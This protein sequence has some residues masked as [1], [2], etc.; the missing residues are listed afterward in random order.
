M[1][2]IQVQLTEALRAHAAWKTRLRDAIDQGASE[3]SVAT[4]GRDDRCPFGTWL[5]GDESLGV[6][7]SPHYEQCRGAHAEFHVAAAEVLELALKGE[8]SEAERKLAPG[9][10]FA[11]ASAAVSKEMLAWQK[12]QATSAP[13]QA[14]EGDVEAGRRRRLSVRTKLL[15]TVGFC[16]ALLAVVGGLGVQGLSSSA[17]LGKALYSESVLPLADAA[18]AGVLYNENRVLMRDLI[19]DTDPGRRAELR[20]ELDRNA[21]LIDKRVAEASATGGPAVSR[22]R[23]N[24]QR[25]APIRQ[26]YVQLV[27]AGRTAEAQQLSVVNAALIGAIGTGFDTLVRS[28]VERARVDQEALSSTASSRSLLM[29]IVLVLGIVVATGLALLVSRGIVRGIRAMIAAS[30][31]TAEGDFTVDLSSVRTRDE[32]EDMA[33]AFQSMVAQL[34]GMILTVTGT[35][36]EVGIASQEMAATSGEAGRAADEIAT[37]VGDVAH[38]AERQ[39]RAIDHARQMTEEMASAAQAGATEAEETTAAV[40]RAHALADQG[41]GAAT[42]ATDAMR[43]LSEASASISEAIGKLGVKTEQIGGIVEAITGIAEQTNLL[44]LNAAIEAA[45]AGE[46]GRGFAVVADEVRK[47]AE[48]ARTAAASIAALVAEIQGDTNAVV[49]VVEGGAEQTRHGV[50][51]VEQARE[52]FTE[53]ATAV[54]DV[55]ER[56][57]R[58]AAAIQQIAASAGQVQVEIADVAAVAEE[59]SASTQQVS[60]S[61]EETSASTRSVASSA[62]ELA[63]TAQELERFISRFR[64]TAG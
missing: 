47:L 60:A 41:A 36:G 33:Y 22:L 34:R 27:L 53:I 1:N 28:G 18:Q 32:I 8:K 62:A 51:V 21:A 11:R 15:G 12:E 7:Q 5:Y 24:L 64:L 9:G 40:R 48:E 46:Q 30:R 14:A 35:A 59:S 20:A 6:R 16:L 23:S 37:A 13:T 49:R 57:D 31:R 17:D 25:Y 43:S 52:S 55:T 61:T 42:G 4:V 2:D 29:L 10:E 26:R 44:A 45:R 56:V 19:L 54:D 58:I 63:Q 3:H 39:V 38:G 50:T